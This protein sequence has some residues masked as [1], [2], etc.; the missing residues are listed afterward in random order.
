MRTRRDPNKPSTERKA[1][2]TK[3]AVAD[4]VRSSEHSRDLV[5]EQR[6]DTQ[7]HAQA[8]PLPEAKRMHASLCSMYCTTGLDIV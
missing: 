8:V 6:M 5:A 4:A 1:T 2:I 3:G 7:I